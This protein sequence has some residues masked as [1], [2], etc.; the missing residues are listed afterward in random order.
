MVFQGIDQLND[1]HCA[2]KEIHRRRS[3]LLLHGGAA[4]L[5]C[6]VRYELRVSGHTILDPS[7][8][9]VSVLPVAVVL[10]HVFI[11]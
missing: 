4:Y 10:T 2:L 9:A 11:S 6:R 8:D 5:V 7:A 3:L 1:L